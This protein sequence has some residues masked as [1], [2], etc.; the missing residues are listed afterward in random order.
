MEVQEVRSHISSDLGERWWR[1]EELIAW[2]CERAHRSYVETELVRRD[3]ADFRPDR[4]EFGMDH[5]P[6]DKVFSI[7]GEGERGL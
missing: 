6:D 7:D 2:S 5:H 1:G 4:N 3:E